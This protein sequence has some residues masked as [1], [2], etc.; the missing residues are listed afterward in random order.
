MAHKAELDFFNVLVSALQEPAQTR[1]SLMARKMMAR[2]LTEG[3][4]YRADAE[5]LLLALDHRLSSHGAGDAVALASLF[6]LPFYSVGTVPKVRANSVAMFDALGAADLAQLLI[7]LERLGFS[8]DPSTLV[9]GLLPAIRG[10][11]LITSAELDILWFNR[12]RWKGA[13]AVVVARDERYKP[14][15][16]RKTWV[17]ATGY[18]TELWFDQ[19]DNPIELVVR[20]PKYRAQPE[21]FEIVCSE[22]GDR[23]LRRDP[24]SSA[25][26]RKEHKER[27]HYLRP[28]P[29]PKMLRALSTEQD[30]ELVTKHSSRWKHREIYLRARAFRRE[31]HYDFVQWQSLRGN[32]DP[33]VCGY[34]FTDTNGAIVGACAFFLH[35]QED[36]S[37]RW[38]LQW[39]WICPDERR[40]GHLDRRWAF[41]R[42]KFGDFEIEGP[43]S[44]AMRQFAQKHGDSHLIEG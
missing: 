42:K 38:G 25:R 13:P 11:S 33:N 39:I 5:D 4:I 1:E 22:C 37:R 44:D 34:L 14:R 7:Q 28:Q 20:G 17:S 2:V 43:V 40:R 36:A 19:D 10:K 30:P 27:M 8:T 35:E 41:F 21:P 18:K 12:R 3:W 24:D 6:E 32:D 16:G 9:D 31:F 15:V 26:H 29:L 23:Y